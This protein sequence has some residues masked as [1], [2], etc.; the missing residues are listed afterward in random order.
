MLD[1]YT[2]GFPDDDLTYL[3]K[4]RATA[5]RELPGRSGRGAAATSKP[6]AAKRSLLPSAMSMGAD[7][8]VAAAV[9]DASSRVKSPQHHVQQTSQPQPGAPSMSLQEKIEMA[10][11]RAER[12]RQEE[13]AR[14]TEAARLKRDSDARALQQQQ[15]QQQLLLQQQQQ[16]QQK[17]L[18]QQ[19]QQRQQLQQQQQQQQQQHQ[20]QQ[21]GPMKREPDVLSPQRR[22]GAATPSGSSGGPSFAAP[23]VAGP[24]GAGT[25][26]PA[27][28]Q[29][30]PGPAPPAHAVIARAML[31]SPS[32][33]A[34]AGAVVESPSNT[35]SLTLEQM[36]VYWQGKLAALDAARDRVR[37]QQRKIEVLLC[38]RPLPS[39]ASTS[40]ASDD[41]DADPGRSAPGVSFARDAGPVSRDF[42][43]DANPATT[44]ARSGDRHSRR[45]S[46]SSYGGDDDDDDAYARD[47]EPQCAEC[48]KRGSGGAVSAGSAL[49]AAPGVGGDA[50][51]LPRT[52]SSQALVQ[53]QQQQQSLMSPRPLTR[54]GSTPPPPPLSKTSCFTPSD[55]CVLI[56]RPYQL[57]L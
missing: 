1:A 13:A 51:L 44:K 46:D 38:G 23:L 57:V 22:D 47:N 50:G 56:S 36:W 48:D 25:L 6:T 18:Q 20:Q 42:G 29:A 4:K 35:S 12:A 11:Q 14:A 43:S 9:A 19:Q 54:S 41:T 40:P 55:V 17:L 39:V 31:T 45:C 53:Q 8:V 24:P 30:F 16:Q 5:H 21:R 33:S 15:Q 32:S 27:A 10:K 49:Y 52:K 3:T 34:T 2:G 28:P 26:V 7:A 37:E